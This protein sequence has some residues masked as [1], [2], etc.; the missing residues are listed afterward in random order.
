MP[1]TSQIFSAF[2]IENLPIVIWCANP[3]VGLDNNMSHRLPPLNGLRAFEVAARHLSFT[4][5]ASE[6]YL[7]RGAVAQ[8]VR[9]LEQA[10]GQ[11]L[12]RLRRNRLSLTAAGER[13]LPQVTSAFRMISETTE[14]IA[15]ALK[16]RVFRLG[17]APELV[18]QCARLAETLRNPPHGLRLQLVK[19]HDLDALHDGAAD[20][21]LRA[22]EGPFPSYNVEPVSLERYGVRQLTG[23]LVTQPGLAGCR[24]HRAL[25]SLLR[26]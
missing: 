8:Q 5:A 19:A 2:A 23:K 10:L 3:C 1:G 9:K 12:F 15:P 26:A 14:E 7:T 13:Y 18:R 11:K 16:G 6:L 20:A 17:V 22:G 25:L 21:I 4:H 24:E